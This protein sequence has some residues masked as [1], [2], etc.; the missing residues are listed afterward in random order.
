MKKTKTTMLLTLLAATTSL[1]A[2]HVSVDEATLRARAFLSNSAGGGASHAPLRSALSLAH[3]AQIGGEAQFYVFNNGDDQGYVIVGADERAT[4]ILGYSQ[5]GS[6]DYNT[7]PDNM[8]AFLEGYQSQ[9]HHAI[10]QDLRLPAE[11][12]TAASRRMAAASRH[13]IAQLVKTKWNQT[14][15]YNSKIPTLPDGTRMYTG[16]AI[17]AVAQMMKY[18]EYPATGTGSKSF[19]RTPTVPSD[20]T[21]VELTFEADFANTHY[22]WS[23]ML[24]EYIE[25][26]DHDRWAQGL[27]GWVGTWTQEQADAVGTLM[28]H[29]SVSADTDYGAI[30]TSGSGASF[31]TAVKGL[32]DNFGYSNKA[33]SLSRDGF[34]DEEWEEA[35]YNELDASRPI[36]YS[37]FTQ[38]GPGHGFVLH[39][40]DASNNLFAI[41][42]GWGGSSD[43][44]FALTGTKAL[45]PSS[46]GA[47]G[48]DDYSGFIK[49]QSAFIGVCPKDQGLDSNIPLFPHCNDWELQVYDY[50]VT[51]YVPAT[52]VTTNDKLH[53]YGQFYAGDYEGFDSFEYSIAFYNS[54][55][56]AYHITPE[57]LTHSTF[58]FFMSVKIPGPSELPSGE[59][60]VVPMVRR[61][62]TSQWVAYRPPLTQT[63]SHTVKVDSVDPIL[64]TSYSGPETI[65]LASTASVKFSVS[66][67]N[68]TSTDQSIYPGLLFQNESGS[69]LIFGSRTTNNLMWIDPGTTV[70]KNIYVN[71]ENFNDTFK[72]K[73][74]I[75]LV[76]LERDGSYTLVA[77][78][79]GVSYLT[80]Q[81]LN[82]NEKPDNGEGD[83]GEGGSDQGGDGEQGGG[84]QG[85]GQGGDGD[86][87][88]ESSIT[89][90]LYPLKHGNLAA[91]YSNGGYNGKPWVAQGEECKYLLDGN[92]NTKWCAGF[93]TNTDASSYIIFS[94]KLPDTSEPPFIEK[95]T[96]VEGGD[97]YQYPN[98]N[99]KEWAIYG[100]NATSAPSRNATGWTLVKAFD[101]SDPIRAVND[102]TAKPITK[103]YEVNAT[104]AYN[105]YKI[106]IYSL[107]SREAGSNNT[108]M[109]MAEFSMTGRNHPMGDV[110]GD[111]DTNIA[112]AIILQY[113]VDQRILDI[114]NGGADVD[115]DNR[116]DNTDITRLQNMILQK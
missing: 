69:T 115:G 24:D 108:T 14:D 64:C 63:Q 98:R 72:G 68:N 30:G 61:K 58:I 73:V 31:T 56:Q 13:D 116:V 47:G 53:L 71:P 112:D 36:L 35:I 5:S 29:I 79:Q 19:K 42:W 101:G 45:S 10:G 18:W 46:L 34:T 15:P 55:G 110:N 37:G 97:T 12:Q 51:D 76:S 28:Y 41:N 103:T 85:G 32:I 6:F 114:T 82:S 54:L 4:E 86:G 11:S 95:V 92:T 20:M 99:W 93:G 80:C 105:Y 3:T 74:T 52:T 77:S 22:D 27:P 17:T 44:Y 111:M 38:S 70:Q 106:E 90:S 43:G 59:Y 91:T 60:T 2:Q 40:Y 9:I 23:N 57:V 102:K 104:A 33:Q 65:D 81:F 84:E 21:P 7:L 1:T 26:W 88:D 39:G 50:S 49:K 113:I 48:G 62:G 25:E 100:M 87:G 67:K 83:G 89:I 78:G 16:C 107:V 109:Q 94:A 66:I 8:R 75:M 96:L